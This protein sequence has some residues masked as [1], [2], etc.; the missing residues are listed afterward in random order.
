SSGTLSPTT[1]S[2]IPTVT[3]L[4]SQGSIPAN[5]MDISF[6]PTTQEEVLIEE[7]G[8]SGTDS[9]K[10]TGSIKYTLH[11]EL[12]ANEQIWP[13]GLNTAIEGSV[14]SIYLIFG[15]IGSSSGEGLDIINTY[16]FLEHFYSVYNTTNGSVGFTTTPFTTATSNQ[17]SGLWALCS[18]L[19]VSRVNHPIHFFAH[20]LCEEQSSSMNTR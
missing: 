17:G 2:L 9:S 15:D 11:T 18:S 5:D 13:R 20:V 12:T 19:L 6:E 8:V 7:L 16:G 14:N 1:S 4:F 3:D 10:I